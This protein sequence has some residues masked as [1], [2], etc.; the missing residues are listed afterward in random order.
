MVLAAGT[1]EHLQSLRRQ[2][3]SQRYTA[4]SGSLGVIGGR[5]AAACVATAGA[6]GSGSG[7]VGAGGF[8]GN[9][10]CLFSRSFSAVIAAS[11]ARS[12]AISS[13]SASTAAVLGDPPDDPD[14]CL[15]TKTHIRHPK[16]AGH[17]RVFGAPG[18]GGASPA[19]VGTSCADR[20]RLEVLLAS[21]P[22]STCPKCRTPPLGAPRPDPVPSGP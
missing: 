14:A 21:D 1:H 13:T 2:R 8:D 6:S 5:P 22:L 18:L 11:C 9:K 16:Q 15:L 3:A 4:G 12:S 7:S 19:E 20:L 17:S 10:A